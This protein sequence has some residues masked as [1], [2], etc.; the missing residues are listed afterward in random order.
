MNPS[1]KV[2][3]EVV[4]EA[5]AAVEGVETV[6][7]PA[8]GVIEEGE[9]S[10][11]QPQQRSG[12]GSLLLWLVLL[13]MVAVGGLLW[14]PNPWQERAHSGVLLLQSWWQPA[15]GE[16]AVQPTAKRLIAPSTITAD[17]PVENSVAAPAEAEVVQ[18]I[19]IKEA[20]AEAVEGQ[21]TE[22][23][24]TEGG[25]TQ[26]TEQPAVPSVAAIAPP[27]AVDQHLNHRIVL[28]NQQL[29]RVASS[30]Q[31]LAQQQRALASASLRQQISFLSSS[32]TGLQQMAQGWQQVAQRVSLPAGARHHAEQVVV[33]VERLLLQRQ[34]WQQQLQEV[35]KQLHQ[36]LD[37]LHGKR[38]AL[39]DIPVLANA[40]LI[41][42][43][44]QQFTLYHLPSVIQQRK[45]HFATRLQQMAAAMDDERWPSDKI[46]RTAR[47]Q[48]SYWLDPEQVASLP[49][50]FDGM[51]QQLRQLR[52]RQVAWLEEVQ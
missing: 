17:R 49:Q 33:E 18:E 36:P 31:K 47:Q 1:S 22:G 4:S 40:P 8:E 45:N 12:G 35:A 34:R 52:Q 25:A 51:Q 24:A 42:W 30:Q 16:Q 13:V 6:D 37:L 48:I 11:E 2:E 50:S 15:V 9:T 27:V 43:L 23:Q 26:V 38:V 44:D 10:V 46:W 29:A 3:E 21:A 14:V 32:T 39:H 41:H 19:T 5:E 20:V 7:A 28:L